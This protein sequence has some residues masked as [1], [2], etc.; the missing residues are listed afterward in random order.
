MTNNNIGDIKIQIDSSIKFIFINPK[1]LT[2]PATKYRFTKVRV[3]INILKDF[4]L[5]D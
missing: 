1:F 3:V 4:I 5:I 2:S